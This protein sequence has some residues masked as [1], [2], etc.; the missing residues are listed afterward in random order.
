MAARDPPL[1]PDPTRTWLTLPAFWKF[2]KHHCHNNPHLFGLACHLGVICNAMIM[3]RLTGKRQ[4][5]MTPEETRSLHLAVAASLEGS[6]EG[7]NKLPVS[8][9][10]LSFPKTWAR[11]LDSNIQGN[12]RDEDAKPGK[13]GGRFALPIGLDTEPLQAVRAGHA[14]L[15]EWCSK[16]GS[17]YRIKLSLAA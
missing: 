5:D 8:A 11:A 16:K 4:Q 10:V 3:L 7:A 2:V 17:N 14:L 6:R 15:T 1:A 13:Y 12:A 9:L